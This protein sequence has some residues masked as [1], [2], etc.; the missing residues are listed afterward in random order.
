MLL[1]LTPNF[2]LFLYTVD[3]ASEPPSGEENV[4]GV[5]SQTLGGFWSQ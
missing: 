5:F 2:S 1:V 4:L 3:Q